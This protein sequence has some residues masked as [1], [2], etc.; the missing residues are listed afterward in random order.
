MSD[1]PKAGNQAAS[2]LVVLDPHCGERLRQ[3]W[4]PG[5]PAWIVM[6]PFNEPT[7]RSLW[8][9]HPDDHLTGITSF[10]FDPG[11]TPEDSFLDY[12]HTID[13]HHGPY[14]NE[15]S[16][17]E[18]EVIGARLTSDVREALSELGFE[19]FSE[20]TDRFIAQR[21]EEEALKERD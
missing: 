21:S 20:R 16:Y 8:A 9:S 3:M 11:A 18:F 2:V 10:Q 15:T 12:L 14:S 13:L 5:R 6:S 7:V 4:Q 17:A 1:A 19:E